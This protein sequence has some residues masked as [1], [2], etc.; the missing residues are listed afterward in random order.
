MDELPPFS[1]VLGRLL[2]SLSNEDVSF[3]EIASL[4]EKDTVLAGNALR[5]VNSAAYGRRGTINSVR[6]A[7]SLL[8]VLKVRNL[9][10]GLSI[11]RL[12]NRTPASKGWS[13]SRFNLHAAA[14]AIMADVLAQHFPVDYPEGAYVAGLFHDAGKLLMAVGLIEEYEEI[15]RRVQAGLGTLEQCENELLGFTHAE[16]SADMADRWNLPRPI[17]HAIARHHDPKKNDLSILINVADAHANA[18]GISVAGSQ[19]GDPVQPLGAFAC[20]GHLEAIRHE[21]QTEFK[22]IR[23]FY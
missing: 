16:L 13:G 21:F 10:L 11:S 4:I 9:M 7:V 19:S 6:H 8:G 20:N 23:S 3:G 22:A 12:W 1:P 5:V 15:Q 14:T 2:G 18:L 17:R